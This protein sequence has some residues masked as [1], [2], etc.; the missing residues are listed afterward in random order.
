MRKSLMKNAAMLGLVKSD[1]RRSQ[2]RA[3]LPAALEVMDTPPNPIGRGMAYSLCLVVLAGLGWA[4]W[5]KVDIVAIA[6]GKVISHRRTQLVQPFETSSVTAVLVSP[7]QQ[8]R[9]GDPLIELDKTVALAERE[10]AQSDLVAA[11]LDELRLTA[12]LEGSSSAPFGTVAGASA[13]DRDRAAAQL[14]TQTAMRASQLAGLE[15]EKLQHAAERLVQQQTV[16]KIEQTL[17]LIAKRASIRD[18]ALAFG[19]TSVLADLEA[20][21]LLV[22]TRSELDIT[23]SKIVSLDATIAGLDQKITATEAEIRSKSMD[24]LGKARDRI[25]AADESLAKAVRRAELQTLRAPYSG[26]VQQMHLANVGAVVTPAQQLLSVVPDDDSIEVEAVLENRDIGFVAAGQR[27]EL[28]VDAFPFTRY[29]L[30]SGTVASVDRDAEAAPVGQSAAQGSQRA[31]DTTDQVEASER[32]RYTVH[33]AL[34]KTVL[35]VDGRTATLLPGMSIKAEILTGKRRIIDFLLAPL[36]EHLHD[37][38]RER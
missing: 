22:E 2:E 24:E 25:H 10:R 36:R 32:L 1:R 18:Q 31:A 4:V 27:V 16:E 12:F 28:K 23:H 6:S 30:L 20:Q 35:D 5:G 7:G 34:Q 33:I 19:N 11:K 29:G 3:F 15:Q 14:T 17:P 13:L 9:A 21:Q 8:V 38:M 26:T 37:A